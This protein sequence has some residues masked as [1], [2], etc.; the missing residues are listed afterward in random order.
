VNPPRNRKG[1]TGSPLPKANA[2]EFYPNLAQLLAAKK[3]AYNLAVIREVEPILL[4]VYESALQSTGAPTIPIDPAQV[5]LQIQSVA[6][7]GL[8]APTAQILESLGFTTDEINLIQSV[9][10][11]P[12]LTTAPSYPTLLVDPGLVGAISQSQTSALPFIADRNND[13]VVNC[14][15]LEIVKAN[16]GKTIGQP[17]FDPRADVNGDG[18]VNLLDFFVVASQIPKGLNC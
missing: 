2:S 11:P 9:P 5:N 1:E 18:A 14:A 3:Y 4:Y 13:L 7:N 12:P 17:G 16:L 8:P 15:D 6:Q 10:E